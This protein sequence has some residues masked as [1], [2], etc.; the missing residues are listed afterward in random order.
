[1]S[2]H[3][4]KKKNQQTDSF[5]IGKGI[6]SDETRSPM[7]GA[8]NTNID[9]RRK[10][11]GILIRRRKLDNNGNA[12]VDLDEADINHPYNHS[13]DIHDKKRDDPRHMT[14]KE[15]REFVK[16]RKKRRPWK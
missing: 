11:T 14:K 8:P 9:F 12:Y 2:K 6:K 7:T 16:A 4:R 13:H 10:K 1:M 3:K 15:M 5:H